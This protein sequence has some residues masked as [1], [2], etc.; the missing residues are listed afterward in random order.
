LIL[1]FTPQS[2]ITSFPFNVPLKNQSH[3]RNTSANVAL[4]KKKLVYF[5]SFFLEN[6]KINQT[7]PTTK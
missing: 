1:D 4:K 5:S 6:L 2:S 3:N 7:N